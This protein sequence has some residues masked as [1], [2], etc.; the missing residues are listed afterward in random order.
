[1]NLALFHLQSL[2]AD[3]AESMQ[4]VLTWHAAQIQLRR[5]TTTVQLKYTD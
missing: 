5:N 2:A 3:L 4:T 1:M